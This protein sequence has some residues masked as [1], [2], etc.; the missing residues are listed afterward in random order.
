MWELRSR[1]NVEAYIHQKF[2]QW[3]I[4]LDAKDMLSLQ[5]VGAFDDLK[6]AKKAGTTAL[7]DWRAKS[8]KE[9]A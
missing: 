2:G 9:A 6:Q 5:Y 1:G 8:N 4:W 3:Q 7:C